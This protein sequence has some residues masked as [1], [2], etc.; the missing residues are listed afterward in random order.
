MKKGVIFI[1]ILTI[2]V[3]GQFSSDEIYSFKDEISEKSEF[4]LNISG[5]NAEVEWKTILKTNSQGNSISDYKASYTST[6]VKI[7]G[8]HKMLYMDHFIKSELSYSRTEKSSNYFSVKN[9]QLSND[10]LRQHVSFNNDQVDLIT[11]A[12][13]V[14]DKDDNY[15]AYLSFNYLKYEEG[16]ENKDFNSSF[17]TLSPYYYYSITNYHSIGTELEYNYQPDEYI[18]AAKYFMSFEEA[19]PN[20]SAGIGYKYSEKSYD[21]GVT[22]NYKV[23]NEDLF[24]NTNFINPEFNYNQEIELINAKANL[25]F[26][27]TLTDEFNTELEAPL[28]TYYYGFSL[29]NRFLNDRFEFGFSYIYSKTEML[30]EFDNDLRGHVFEISDDPISPDNS[31]G[32]YVDNKFGLTFKFIP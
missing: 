24:D 7:N 30:V 1:L 15:G 31:K 29:T 10:S 23:F 27:L 18:D 6:N 22:F 3:F 4:G 2:S 9:P 17:I 12:V 19:L 28:P 32:D 26:G 16:N 20:Y 5:R 21:L 8:F 25:N 13:R 11:A 14:N